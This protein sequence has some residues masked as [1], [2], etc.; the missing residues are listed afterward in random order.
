MTSDVFTMIVII[1][2]IS[3]IFT[4]SFFTLGALISSLTHR[5]VTSLAMSL[6]IWVILVIALPNLGDYIASEIK[7]VEPVHVVE[8]RVEN[9]QNELRKI[10][11]DWRD[12][13]SLDTWTMWGSWYRFRIANKEF[14]DYLNEQYIPFYEPKRKHNKG[15]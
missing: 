6:F 7:E 8:K 15:N 14:V 2:I 11:S 1:Y 9:L 10:R 3:I 13:N 5:S 12:E 4:A